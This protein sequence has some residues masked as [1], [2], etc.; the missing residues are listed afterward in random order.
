MKNRAKK[1]ADIEARLSAAENDVTRIPREERQAMI[2]RAFACD[3]ITA[4][5]EDR[6]KFLRR[7]F[8]L[9]ERAAEDIEV[10]NAAWR[11]FNDPKFIQLWADTE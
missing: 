11:G 9:I 3:L 5:P 8:V 10:R 1:I 7:C 4:S 2:E 6:E